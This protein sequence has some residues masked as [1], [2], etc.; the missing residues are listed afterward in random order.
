MLNEANKSATRLFSVIMQAITIIFPHQLF[1]EHPAISHDRPVYLVEEGLFFNQYCFHKQKLVLHR[2]TM[3]MF[4]EHHQQ[5]NGRVTY[6][7]A[8]DPLSDIRKLITHLSE[9]GVTEIHYADVVDNWLEKR[10]SSSCEAHAVNQIKY[11]SPNFLNSLQDVKA[12][13]EKKKTYLQTDFYIWQRKQQKLLLN[14]HNQPEG[15]KWT[16]DAENR[17]NFQKRSGS[18]NCSS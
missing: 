1:K 3:K 16:Y 14:T 2:A 6:V 17:K 8:R 11:T 12:F 5:E 4:Q 13:F 9:Q 18:R 10:I 15:G 7:E